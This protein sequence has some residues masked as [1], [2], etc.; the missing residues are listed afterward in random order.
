MKFIE[1]RPPS[2]PMAFD[3]DGMT[4][5]RRLI[6]R[7]IVVAFA[8]VIIFIRMPNVFLHPA[9]WGEDGSIFFQLSWLDRW[10]SII[11]GG[12]AGY[13]TLF[14]WLVG[15]FAI[16][17]PVGVAPAI[18]N[19]AAIVLTLAVVWLVTSPRLPLPAKPLLAVAV[20]IVPAAYEELGTLANS[21]WIF[22]IGAFA[23]LLMAPSKSRL[24]LAAEATFVS[25]FSLTGPFSLLLL[26]VCGLQ[27]IVNRDVTAAARR[28]LILSGLIAAGAAVEC[29][30]I[31]RNLGT[32]LTP[33]LEPIPSS[34]QLWVVLPI[35]RIADPIGHV[36]LRA[37]G[38][39]PSLPIAFIAYGSIAYF[40]FRSPYRQQKIA[41]LLLAF[42]IIISGLIKDRLVLPLNGMRYYYAAQVF[43]IWFFCCIPQNVR[44]RELFTRSVAIALIIMVLAGANRPRVAENSEWPAWS[45]EI[46]S[47]LPVKI[48]TA[49]GG[50][51]VT[52][53]ADPNGPL[54]RFATWRGKEIH[55]LGVPRDDAACRGALG[56][57]QSDIDV[58]G[59]PSQWIMRGW[60][61]PSDRQRAVIAIVITDFS[62]RVLGFGF[63]GFAGG[64]DG[65]SLGWAG[66]V[67]NPVAN[68]RALAIVSDGSI[69]L[70]GLAPDSGTL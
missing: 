53:P 5:Q 36:M 69:T 70:C 17:F 19:A 13:L 22:P 4:Q 7:L 61:K 42:A 26:P 11:T 55:Q 12:T 30:Y 66:V 10:S 54:A 62:N 31:L 43:S 28:A 67:Q 16:Y 57:A 41:M 2:D 25:I 39:G 59:G 14:Q 9:F 68:I 24:V 63:P 20:V 32:A 34:W 40:A 49:P 38:E 21:Q 52:L 6:A 48:P 15:N 8:F 50:W 29:I 44:M 60:A 35:A 47:G 3:F 18:F 56:T 45:T 23:L 46:H 1:P 33:N 65:E 58:N 51:F 37:L 27:I 64:E